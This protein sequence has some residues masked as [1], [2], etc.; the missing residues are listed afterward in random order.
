MET[1]EI[2]S[3]ICH[4]MQHGQGGTHIYWGMFSAYGFRPDALDDELQQLIPAEPYTLIAFE[5][6]NW[7]HDFSPW[8]A[9][10]ITGEDDFTG[11]GPQMLAW[12]EDECIPTVEGK[13]G[14]PDARMIVGYSMAGMFSL[15][16][17]LS[18]A[19]F[20]GVASCSGSLWYPEFMDFARKASAP[21]QS[22]AYLS[23]GDAEERSKNA[24]LATVGDCTRE[25]DQLL[26]A[27]P[28]VAAHTLVWNKGGHFY[29]QGKRTADGV[30]WVVR[31]LARPK[32][33]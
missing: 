8:P 12:L 18:S 7:D 13:F 9:G 17:F 26:E 33:E 15:W 31:E 5:A 25:E 24:V 29:K 20:Q 14:A 16:A 3:H 4:V 11:E 6:N 32:Q 23:L 27:D 30:V 10:N 28:N 19:A 22:V 2:G 1:F 21:E